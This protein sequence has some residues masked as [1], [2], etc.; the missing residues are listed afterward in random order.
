MELVYDSE[1]DEKYFRI[2]AEYLTIIK[3]MYAIKK[4]CRRAM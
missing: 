4:L 3:K 2:I 1:D